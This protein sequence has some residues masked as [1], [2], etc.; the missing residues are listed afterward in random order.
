MSTKGVKSE[1]LGKLTRAIRYT[2]CR[3]I[4]KIVMVRKV[5]KGAVTALFERVRPASL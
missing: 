3:I 1:H 4:P 2:N 5:R